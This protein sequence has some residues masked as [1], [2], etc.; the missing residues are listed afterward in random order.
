V[1]AALRRMSFFVGC[2]VAISLPSACGGNATSGE[3]PAQG[4]MTQTCSRVAACQPDAEADCEQEL[5]EA[6]REAADSDCTEA[7]DAILECD[8]EQPGTCGSSQPYAFA[9]RC[10][11]LINVLMECAGGNEPPEESC[12]G[13]GG[14][15]ANPPCE[16]TCFVECTS[17]GA[18][19]SGQQGSMSCTCTSGSN[20][21]LVFTAA[22]CGAAFDSAQTACR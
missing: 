2:L 6:R 4:S 15:C 22:D 12:S 21:G 8:A 5:A 13:G 20:A 14:G 3:G 11:A 17:Y 10:E 18:Q 9:P 19:C 16:M 7:F 1:E